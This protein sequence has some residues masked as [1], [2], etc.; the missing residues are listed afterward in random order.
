M[1]GIKVTTPK[2]T[3]MDKLRGGLGKQGQ[4]RTSGRK[5]N[6]QSAMGDSGV[7]GTNPAPNL[8]P[9]KRSEGR[10]TIPLKFQETV[11]GDL[12]STKRQTNKMRNVGA[13]RGQASPAKVSTTKAIKN[14][15]RTVKGTKLGTIPRKF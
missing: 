4:L 13:Q 8:A 5:I 15:Y 11:G 3:V 6:N 2:T 9:Y 10:D 12:P 7:Y 1:K 14:K